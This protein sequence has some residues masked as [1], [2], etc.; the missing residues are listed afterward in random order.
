[1]KTFKNYLC[2]SVGVIFFT[3]LIDA[4]VKADSDTSYKLNGKWIEAVNRKDTLIFNVPDSSTLALKRGN[5]MVNGYWL[6]KS[7]SGFYEY[8]FRHDSI[9]VNNMVW[10]CICFPAYYFLLSKDNSTLITG[11]FFDSSKPTTAHITFYRLK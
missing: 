3:L 10:D 11:N 6:P 9:L 7:G 8:K 1:M 5:E 4:C 2:W